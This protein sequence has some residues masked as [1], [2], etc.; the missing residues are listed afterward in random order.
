MSVNPSVATRAVRAAFPSRSALVAT[1]I[2]CAKSVTSS[3]CSPAR[4]NA[5]STAAMT[6]ADWSPG[7]VGAFAVTTRSPTTSTASVK[8]PPTST[9]R[10]ARG[11]LLGGD[12]LALFG[13]CQVLMRRAVSVVRQRVAL[14]RGAATS[15]RA[16]LE[17]I[18]VGVVAVARLAGQPFV[19]VGEVGGDDAPHLGLRAHRE[20]HPDVVE[21]RPR[22]PREVVAVGHQT[23]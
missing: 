7:V 9:P 15:G 3:A 12:E 13:L 23:L 22:R 1:V 16:A 4:A 19:G 5:D 11:P 10:R 20:M 21:E 18:A 6:P 8:V 14:T 17:R 2:P